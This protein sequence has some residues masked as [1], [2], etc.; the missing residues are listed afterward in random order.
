MAKIV[1]N[2]EQSRNR[3]ETKYVIYDKQSSVV[4]F[5]Y[6]VVG[7]LC[8]W[9]G[10]Y[11]RKHDNHH[12]SVLMH[13]CSVHGVPS[14]MH[15]VGDG[16]YLFHT[17]CMGELKHLFAMAGLDVEP[18]YRRCGHWFF[19]MFSKKAEYTFTGFVVRTL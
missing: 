9:L 15:Y 12:M 6:S 17:H 10:E 18:Q 19:S 3:V 8:S 14:S 7:T 16:K 2:V 13:S 4:A 5:G 1:L 11:L